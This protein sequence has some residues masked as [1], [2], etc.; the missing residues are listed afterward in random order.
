MNF[1]GSTKP[2]YVAIKSMKNFQLTMSFGK[3]KY[4]VGAIVKY[5]ARC[6]DSLWNETLV[7]YSLDENTSEIKIKNI[8]LA[9]LYKCQVAITQIG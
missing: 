7:A 8:S 2:L 3:P 5:K 1:S 4:H 9:K 6:K